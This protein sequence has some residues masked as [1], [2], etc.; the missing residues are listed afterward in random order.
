M[1]LLWLQPLSAHCATGP[2]LIWFPLPQG[3]PESGPPL[4]E[5]EKEA[6][7]KAAR[8][9]LRAALEEEGIM[10]SEKPDPPPP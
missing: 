6:R 10:P 7:L 3:P 5:A 2:Q 4:T 9:E 1:R 8:N